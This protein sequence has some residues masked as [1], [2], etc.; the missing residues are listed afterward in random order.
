MTFC[1]SRGRA[2]MILF[3]R[4]LSDFFIRFL[5]VIGWPICM[6]LLEWLHNPE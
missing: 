5:A 1:L 6:L 3:D 4:F 2:I